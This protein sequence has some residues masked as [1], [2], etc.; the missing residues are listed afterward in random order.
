MRSNGSIYVLTVFVLL[1]GY[2]SYQWWFNQN[3]VVKRQLG[4]LASV[5]TAPP[6][7]DDLVRLTRLA[8]LRRLLADDIRISSG[9]SSPELSSRDAVVAAAANW[10]PAGGGDVEFLDV[11]VKVDADVARAYLTA[12]VTTRDGS[13]GEPVRDAREASLS[14]IRR[15]GVWVVSSVDVKEPSP[16]SL[17]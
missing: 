6:G 5:L 3:R 8:R 15:D 16:R 2:F 1:A 7:E 4:E 12:E 14:M 11:D 17:P 10:R 9:R 13:T